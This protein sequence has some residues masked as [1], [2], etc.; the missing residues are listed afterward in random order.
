MNNEEELDPIIII[1]DIECTC[2]PTNIPPPG[3]Q[4]EIIEI[5]YSLLNYESNIISEHGSIIV[6]PTESVVSEFCK[7]LTSLTQ[8]KVE[9]G[10]TFEEACRTL[11][12]DFKSGSRLWASFGYFDEKVF[13]NMC[14]RRNIPYPLINQHLNIKAVSTSLLGQ[15]VKGIGHTL[16]LLGLNFEGQLHSGNWD[17]YNA[18]RILQHFARKHRDNLCLDYLK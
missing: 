12:S 10:I 7:D 2:W 8:E 6:R 9:R 14:E 13:R 15:H 1:I 4:Q 5:G 11:Q 18:A 3:M 16:S 17:S